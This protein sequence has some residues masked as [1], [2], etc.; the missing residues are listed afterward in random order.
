MK[1]LENSLDKVFYYAHYIN[2]FIADTMHLDTE[3]K[4]AY[5][6]IIWK[7]Y[8]TGGYINDNDI[9]TL[10]LQNNISHSVYTNVVREFVNLDESLGYYIDRVVKD[11][12]RN[13]RHKS[14]SSKGGQVTAAKKANLAKLEND[15]KLFWDVYPNNKNKSLALKKW[16]SSDDPDILVKSLK[17]IKHN[18]QSGE[19]NK[20]E[21]KF[22]PH[23]ATFIN[24]ERYNDEVSSKSN[25]YTKGL[26]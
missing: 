5:L 12:S 8:R 2:D 26:K 14:I 10:S 6:T 3:H 17:V 9:K 18:L 1:N 20:N 13:N 21:T 23:A 4:Y 16:M 22:I 24:Q 25:N 7:M 19:W 11:L 15:F